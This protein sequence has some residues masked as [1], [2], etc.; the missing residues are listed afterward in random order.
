MYMYDFS[1]KWVNVLMNYLQDFM[2]YCAKSRTVICFW[3]SSDHFSIDHTQTQPI[4]GRP[5]LK[6]R[7]VIPYL[8][9][10][11]LKNSIRDGN[12]APFKNI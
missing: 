1:V 11:A 10:I 4:C 7:H 5:F 9:M 3:W 8:K 12:D 6:S 2:S